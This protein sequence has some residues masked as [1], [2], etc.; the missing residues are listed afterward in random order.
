MD[1]PKGWYP[2]PNVEGRD[3]WWNGA[4]WTAHTRIATGS[5]DPD[6]RVPPARE[7]R[8]GVG[9]ATLP[10]AITSATFG[11]LSL[12]TDPFFIPS[13]VSLLLGVAAV[14]SIRSAPEPGIRTAVLIVGSTGIALAVAG[15]II[16]A[17]G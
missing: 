13:L 12:F 6:V 15:A 10:T 7:V 1:Y 14:A 11:F 9:S 17:I 5:P 3:Q 4:A 16:L 2:S 8:F